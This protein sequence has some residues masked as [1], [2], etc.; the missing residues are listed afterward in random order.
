MQEYIQVLDFTD[1]QTSYNHLTS[2]FH[3]N[4]KKQ[5]SFWR[6]GYTQTEKSAQFGQTWQCEPG[7]KL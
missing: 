1:R 3:Q 5:E 4:F 6:D 7:D 2:N